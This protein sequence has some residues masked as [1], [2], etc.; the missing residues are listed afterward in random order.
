MLTTTRPTVIAAGITTFALTDM[1]LINRRKRSAFNAEQ[2]SLYA[3]RLLGAIETE[4]AGL[5]LDDDQTLILNRERARVQAE[6]RKKQRPWGKLIMGILTGGLKAEEGVEV[7]VVPTE[8]EILEKIGVTQANILES[9][10]GLRKG[11]LS[12]EGAGQVEEV[13][14]G[15]DELRLGESRIEGGGVLQA[16][17]EKRREGERALEAVGV[18]GG[19][20]DRVAEQA[21]EKAKGKGDWNWF[22]WRRS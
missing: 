18:E 20:L 3:T 11:E 10:D 5:P 7:A 17:E 12:L 15:D 1:M 4:R 9:A 14:G 2:R 21:V 16:V 22:N 19:M 13:V 6:E 8:A